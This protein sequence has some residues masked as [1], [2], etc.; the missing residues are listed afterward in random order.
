M[1]T[2]TQYRTITDPI[3][4][5]KGPLEN[6]IPEIL[7]V[8]EDAPIIEGI[9]TVL[10]DYHCAITVAR[11]GGIEENSDPEIVKYEKVEGTKYDDQT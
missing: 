2:T 8:D 4:T 9:D 11:D 3:P 5:W 6:G 10:P 7:T 1:P